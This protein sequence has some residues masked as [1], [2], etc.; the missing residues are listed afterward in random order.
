MLAQTEILS[1]FIKLVYN[2]F[3]KFLLMTFLATYESISRHW[4][5]TGFRDHLKQTAHFSFPFFQLRNFLHFSW[6]ILLQVSNET[7]KRNSTLCKTFA[8]N[9]YS[10]FVVCF[11]HFLIKIDAC[12]FAKNAYIGWTVNIGSKV[13]LITTITNKNLGFTSKFVICIFIF[14]RILL[15]NC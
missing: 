15:P 10:K 11:L 5:I 2:N 7:F 9:K 3:L 12:L 14:N 1:E 4:F 8:G 6:I 13:K